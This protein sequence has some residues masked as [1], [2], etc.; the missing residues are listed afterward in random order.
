MTFTVLKKLKELMKE[1]QK[2]KKTMSVHNV[3]YQSGGGKPKNKPKLNF[4][5]EKY[6][7]LNEKFTRGIKGSF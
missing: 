1:I 7:N 2:V 3:N 4:G 5:I 6:S